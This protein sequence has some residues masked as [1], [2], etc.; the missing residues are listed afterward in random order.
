MDLRRC[1]VARERLL[2]KQFQ[3]GYTLGWAR[4][5]QFDDCTKAQCRTG[6]ESILNWYLE[7]AEVGALELPTRI[8]GGFHELCAVCSQHARQSTVAGR[9]KMW[10]QLPE[11]FD[12][13]PWSEL[14]NKM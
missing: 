10:E 14:K 9:K 4:K 6:R 12:L 8:M 7:D 2:A 11:F 1:V 13:P 3:E 5:W